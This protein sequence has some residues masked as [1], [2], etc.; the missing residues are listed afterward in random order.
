MKAIQRILVVDDEAAIRKI[1][2]VS[3]QQ[4]GYQIEEAATGK[5]G[6]AQA[7]VFRPELVILDLCL[8]DVE[9]F[10]ARIWHLRRA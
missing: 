10:S 4:H 8:P 1:L 7:I 6:L 5:E 2:R 9:G 3:L